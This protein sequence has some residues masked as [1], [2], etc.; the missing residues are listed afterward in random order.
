MEKRRFYFRFLDFRRNYIELP[1]FF[2]VRVGSI[3]FYLL[4]KVFPVCV[5]ITS[6]FSDNQVG[7]SFHVA[8]G[9][10]FTVNHVHGK[11]YIDKQFFLIFM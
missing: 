9:Q 4:K 6:L 5:L 2:Y 11:Y 8:P 3:F 7:G 1:Y 10:S